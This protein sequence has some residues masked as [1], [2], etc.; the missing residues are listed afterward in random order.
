MMAANNPHNVLTDLLKEHTG[1]VFASS[2]HWRI[3]MVLKPIMKE[4][5]IPDLPILASLLQSDRNSLLARQCVEAMINNETCFFRDQANFALLTGPLVDAVREQRGASKT[6][7]IWS[8]ACS[9]GQ[10]AYSLAITFAENAEKWQDWNIVIYASDVSQTAL[11]K[12]KAG[13][14][15]QFEIQRGLP[16]RMMLKYFSQIGEEWQ[17]NDSLRK[18]V[19]FCGHNQ[20]TPAVHFGKFD[21]ILCRNMLMYLSEENRGVVLDNLH[22]SLRSDG[23]LMLGSSETVFGKRVKFTPSPE[24][25]GF[26]EP[27]AA[28]SISYPNLLRA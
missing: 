14:Y 13:R 15:S 17:A 28:S 12:A 18:M 19:N 21:I 7:R 26:Y 11:S 16:V 23:F 4:H 6:I 10:E 25:R 5:S 20:L 1:Q 24:F 2:R 9:T 3:E 8:S 27:G 22:G